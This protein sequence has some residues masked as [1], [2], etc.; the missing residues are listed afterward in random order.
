MEVIREKKNK[1]HPEQILLGFSQED[2]LQ[3]IDGWPG[4]RGR[5][6]ALPPRKVRELK[7]LLE[8][9]LK[10]TDKDLPVEPSTEYTSTL[11]I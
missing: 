10:E 7:N 4:T 2:L 11:H 5:G 1:R 8:T 9:V 3:A 6:V